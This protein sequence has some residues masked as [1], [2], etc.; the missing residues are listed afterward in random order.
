MSE[1]PYRLFVATSGNRCS[2]RGKVNGTNLGIAVIWHN[3]PNR[4]D[5]AEATDAITHLLAEWEGILPRS[6]VSTVAPNTQVQAQQID[7]FLE[8]GK[9]PDE[10]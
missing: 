10:P 8:T 3:Q 9:T 2:F 1:Q 7:R 4:E 6:V 5:V